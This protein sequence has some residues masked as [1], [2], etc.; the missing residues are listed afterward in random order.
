MNNE[1]ANLAAKR[2]QLLQK[3]MEEQ[4]RPK[5]QREILPVP[6]DGS[7]LPTSSVQ[8]GIWFLE[9]LSPPASLHNMPL[10]LRAVGELDQ[11]ALTHA[12]NAI[13]ARHE[14]LRS[15]FAAPEG[16]PVQT[17]S[18]SSTIALDFIQLRAPDRASREQQALQLALEASGRPFDLAKGPLLRLMILEIDATEHWLL[19]DVHHMAFDGWSGGVFFTD[20]MAFYQAFRLDR[21]AALP[22]LR[23]QYGDYAAWQQQRLSSP[24]QQL[25]IDYWLQQLQGCPAAL[26]LPT[27]HPR[28]TQQSFQ[29]A[30]YSFTLP[31]ALVEALLA[32][33][34]REGATLFHDDICRVC[35]SDCTTIHNRR[36]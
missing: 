23:I 6:R 13:I 29:G 8:Q 5:A 16:L 9:Q 35:P 20:M 19:F 26:S 27:D 31:E 17:V 12:V 15:T 18:A 4:A 36:I 10:L 2:R 30:L 32:L 7:P 24:E 21:T 25:Q 3:L 33:S 14:I 11:Q 22:D 1:A 34:R 28:P